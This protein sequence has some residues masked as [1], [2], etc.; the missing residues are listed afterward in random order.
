MFIPKFFCLRTFYAS[1]V[2]WKIW[3]G[4]PK[5]QQWNSTDQKIEKDKPQFMML[6][7]QNI[8]IPM[9]RMRFDHT[10]PPRLCCNFYTRYKILKPNPCYYPHS[11]FFAFYIPW[12]ILRHS[13]FVIVVW[14]L[15]IDFFLVNLFVRFP[16]KFYYN[17]IHV[18]YNWFVLEWFQQ[19][20][21]WMVFK[22]W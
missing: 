16:L 5:R 3:T 8:M 21:Q 18:V 6:E 15:V 1:Q 10:R 22:P 19:T 7:F 11:L 20:D 9:Q 12:S 2:K 4:S 13:H 14:I 17:I